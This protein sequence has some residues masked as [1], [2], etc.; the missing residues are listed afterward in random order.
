MEVLLS[1]NNYGFQK[2]LDDFKDSIYINIV[3]YNI[4]SGDTD[5]ELLNL[6]KSLENKTIRI[7]TN[8]PKRF[9]I[10]Y[11]TSL[12]ENANKSIKKYLEKLE[13]S[14]FKSDVEIYFNFKNH[15][16][17]YS[18]DN[19]TYIGSQNFSDESKNNYEVGIVIDNKKI[20]KNYG[21]DFIEELIY[22]HTDDTIR[23]YGMDIENMKND[24]KLKIKEISFILT[25]LDLK[26]DD[27]CEGYD[28]I[29]EVS[30][31]FTGIKE[32][33]DK[34][35]IILYS[36][37]TTLNFIKIKNKLDDVE[38]LHDLKK[39]IEN[40]ECEI[41]EI[42]WEISSSGDFKEIYY[43]PNE[44]ILEN[45]YYA[46]EEHLERAIEVESVSAYDYCDDIK[47]KYKN[48]IEKFFISLPKE[49]N[50]F[51]ELLVT[52]EEISSNYEIIDNTL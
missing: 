21:D 29:C 25:S 3:T 28:F 37:K 30:Y 26:I 16:K 15:S 50:G 32:I 35:K 23:F 11:S 13:P 33:L 36:M 17:I 31:K 47:E 41:D 34:V 43:D 42:L 46:D 22:D 4:S 14:S 12:K 2:I 1:N 18:T 52:I 9:S 51:N 44:R 8:I 49:I 10:Y 39:S 5:G 20:G 24:F 45:I 40:I 19:Y 27:K 38:F 7:I 48:E 6:L